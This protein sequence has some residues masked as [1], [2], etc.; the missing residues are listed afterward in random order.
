MSR[1]LSLVMAG[2]S[3]LLLAA[4]C[5]SSVDWLIAGDP[6][7]P[8]TGSLYEIVPG[9]PR[10]SVRAEPRTVRL[11]SSPP[12]QPTRAE[13]APD[14]ELASDKSEEADHEPDDDEEPDAVTIEIGP[15]I[16]DIDL[17]IR[18]VTAGPAAIPPPAP[19]RPKGGVPEL[20]A[21]RRTAGEGLP[22]T[23]FGSTGR[24][25]LEPPPPGAAFPDHP[26]LV[27]AFADLDGD[28]FVGIT[29]LDQNPRDAVLEARELVPV[30]RRY[31]I[32]DGST[33]SGE[34]FVPVGGPAGAELDIVLSAVTYAGLRLE[35]YYGGGVPMGPAIMTKLPF[36][37]VTSPTEVIG[38][39]PTSAHAEALVGADIAPLIDPDPAHPEIGEAFTMRLDGSQPSIDTARIRSRKFVRFS[40]GEL[41]GEQPVE[42][43]SHTPLR[44]GL[45]PAGKRVVYR[46]LQHLT[47]PDDGGASRTTLHVLP[48]DDLGNITAP[49]HPHDVEVSSAGPVRITWPDRDGDPHRETLRVDS[50]RGVEVVIDDLGGEWDDHNTAALELRG[51]FPQNQLPVSLPDPDVD[52]SGRVDDADVEIV[53]AAMDE[54]I[55][56]DGFRRSLD[57]D[58][59]GRIREPDVEIVQQALGKH[60]PT[61]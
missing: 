57:L 18:S 5:D 35:S 42:L 19:A 34:L 21:S 37:P 15:E 44:P 38:T 51:D 58:G 61:P 20:T 13:A 40:F 48:T 46:M 36:H 45:D 53:E 33:A 9:A 31:A 25:P 4:D 32:A 29:E 24:L 39:R 54:R 7:D 2:L 17:V 12:P 14:H 30:A 22:F 55:G 60:L 16:G 6:I 27:L 3:A 43:E 28:G 10:I 8:A 41:V 59:T 26:V 52:D 49:D 11:D 56:D 23:V 47:L 1:S 50:T